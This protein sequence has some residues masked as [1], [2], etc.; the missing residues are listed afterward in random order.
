MLKRI[1]KSILA[2]FIVAADTH[3]QATLE[4]QRTKL[5]VK[6]PTGIPL[7]NPYLPIINRQYMLMLRAASELDSR[8]PAARASR[9]A[10]RHYHP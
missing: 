3:R 6:S 4:L 8:Q 2:G 9:P 1:D 7:Q 10:R 5:L